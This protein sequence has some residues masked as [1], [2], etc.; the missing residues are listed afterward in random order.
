MHFLI[1]AAEDFMR[2]FNT[3]RRL[4]S[5][6]LKSI[7]TSVVLLSCVLF[8]APIAGAKP[9][10]PAPVPCSTTVPPIRN[11][12]LLS[13]IN[14]NYTYKA[15]DETGG[16]TWHRDDVLE[17]LNTLGHDDGNTFAEPNGEQPNFY[18]TFTISNDGQDHFTGSVKLEG[19]AQGYITTINKYQYSYASSAKLVQDLTDEAYKFVHSGWHDGRPE[20]M[21]AAQ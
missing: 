9:R 20:C 8:A 7:C 11:H 21:N 2:K 14:V 1:Y 5:M 3:F 19:W 10:R 15:V 12:S 4:P 16:R 6:N 13:V 18:I 17:E